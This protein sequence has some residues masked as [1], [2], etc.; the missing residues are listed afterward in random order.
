[1]L[2]PIWIVQK[3]GFVGCAM[4]FMMG[5]FLHCLAGRVA[6][7]AGFLANP[8]KKV[9]G[10]IKFSIA[11][12]RNRLLLASRIARRK[13]ARHRAKQSLLFLR[14]QRFEG[15]LYSLMRSRHDGPISFLP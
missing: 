7:C 13:I 2:L 4:I 11:K 15:V 12:M 8:S 3:P 5:V 9:A 14:K 10:W 1:M 6:E